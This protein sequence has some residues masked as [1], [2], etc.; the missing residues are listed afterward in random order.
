MFVAKTS[1]DDISA[2]KCS[3]EIKFFAKDAQGQACRFR[4]NQA[5]VRW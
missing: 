3:F 1:D 5:V 4:S 2:V